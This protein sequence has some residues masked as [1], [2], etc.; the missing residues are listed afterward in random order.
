MCLLFSVGLF[1]YWNFFC[2]WKKE[3]KSVL[4]F[5]QLSTRS[6]LTFFQLVE[7]LF[8]H[9][10]DASGFRLWKKKVDYIWIA[11]TRRGQNFLASIRA[12]EHA[13]LKI[14]N[15]WPNEKTGSHAVEDSAQRWF[16]AKVGRNSISWKE[17][18]PEK[19]PHIRYSDMSL[20]ASA[21]AR[22]KTI[23]KFISMHKQTC[24]NAHYGLLRFTQ[25]CNT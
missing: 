17:S 15:T 2:A 6:S 4:I 5:S 8:L 16:W 7:K 11:Y 22:T 23:W 14:A 1:Y 10:V 25:S 13:V 21:S 19:L 9:N 18:R 3:V 12:A 24:S 20:I